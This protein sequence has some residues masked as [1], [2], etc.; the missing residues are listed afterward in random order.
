MVPAACFGLL[1]PLQLFASAATAV[2]GV[3]NNQALD[4]RY[5][6]LGVE[7]KSATVLSC[8]DL[9]VQVAFVVGLELPRLEAGLAVDQPP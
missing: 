1:R 6:G 5:R 2:F 8:Q 9:V 3:L 4:I 7:L